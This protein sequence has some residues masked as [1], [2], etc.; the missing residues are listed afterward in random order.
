L[1]Y[2]HL[3]TRKCDTCKW[4]DTTDDNLDGLCQ[5][6]DSTNYEYNL[7]FVTGCNKHEPKGE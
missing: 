5:N 2:K 3:Q 4:C 6:I 7:A 1:R